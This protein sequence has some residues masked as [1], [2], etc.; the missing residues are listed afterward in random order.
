MPMPPGLRACFH[1]AVT[2]ARRNHFHRWTRPENCTRSN[3]RPASLR[4]ERLAWTQ[5]GLGLVAQRKRNQLPFRREGGS[6]SICNSFPPQLKSR[7]S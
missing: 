6:M 7:S 3:G 1:G 5:A 2:S 4:A